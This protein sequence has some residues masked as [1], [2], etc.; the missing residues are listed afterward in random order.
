MCL[1]FCECGFI[2]GWV[3]GKHR[4]G[5]ELDQGQRQ[6]MDEGRDSGWGIG[7]GE[8]ALRLRLCVW[9]WLRRYDQAAVTR[10][11]MVSFLVLNGGSESFVSIFSFASYL[12][13]SSQC[14]V[15]SV[16]AFCW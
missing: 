11:F 9:L 10:V 2:L 1:F 15:F 8:V 3:T 14:F 7:D 13:F 4:D 12:I 6:I 5:G 16:S